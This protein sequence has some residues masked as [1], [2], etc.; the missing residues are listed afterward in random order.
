MQRASCVVSVHAWQMEEN[1]EEEKGGGVGGVE[2]ENTR[3]CA[4]VHA[5]IGIGV[6]I[7]TIGFV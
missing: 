6:L 7:S 2:I 3:S 1:R 5:F 4:C